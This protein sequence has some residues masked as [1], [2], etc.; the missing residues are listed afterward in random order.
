MSMTVAM[1]DNVVFDMG[2]ERV[3]LLYLSVITRM[4][5]LSCASLRAVRVGQ[6]RCYLV[7]LWEEITW[8]CGVSSD[9]GL[10]PWHMRDRIGHEHRNPLP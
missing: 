2:M 3:S 4:W 7:G 1:Y 5:L 6:S 9:G 8:S 10:F